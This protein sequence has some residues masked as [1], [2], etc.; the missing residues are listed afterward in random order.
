MIVLDTNVISELMK[1]APSL[2]VIDWIDQQDA[3]LLMVTTIT[4]A[5]IGYGL[6]ALPKGKRRTSL[7]HAFAKTIS[8]G[9]AHRVL[10]F[11]EAAA[12]LY[13][14]LMAKRKEAGKPLSILDGQIASIALSYDAI[15]ATR[16]VKDFVD[17]DIGLI[18]PFQ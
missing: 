14:S 5:E 16:N 8:E 18:D 2:K 13:G 3:T 6:C 7:E 10:D 12:Q 15:L 17:C 4:L 9:F 1:P 11:D